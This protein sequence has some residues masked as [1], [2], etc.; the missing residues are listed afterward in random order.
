MALTF[1]VEDS[2]LEAFEAWYEKHL[3]DKH[4][5]LESRYCGAIGGSVGWKFINTG[6]GT[7]VVVS[8]F[9]GDEVNVTD[10]GSW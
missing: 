9:C 5:T 3:L 6:L 7:I 10:F 4:P 8:C 2:E 1:V